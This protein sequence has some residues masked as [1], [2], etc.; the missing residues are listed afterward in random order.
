MFSTTGA[1]RPAT[2]VCPAADMC[3]PSKP[4][5][6]GSSR[7]QHEGCAVGRSDF[8]PD[9][10]PFRMEEAAQHGRDTTRSQLCQNAFLILATMTSGGVPVAASL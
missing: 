2:T 1:R 9:R 6:R 5:L 3:S 8:A 4:R 10:V 7:I